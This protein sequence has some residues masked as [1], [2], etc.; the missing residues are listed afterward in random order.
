M[1]IQLYLYFLKFALCNNYSF[2]CYSS[3]LS[4]LSFTISIFLFFNPPTLIYVLQIYVLISQ[5]I[6]TDLL[7]LPD[8]IQITDCVKIWYSP[9][10]VSIVYLTVSAAIS[11]FLI[12]SSCRVLLFFFPLSLFTGDVFCVVKMDSEVIG[13]S[14]SS[15]PSLKLISSVVSALS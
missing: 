13:L 2:H 11:F 5:L 12:L 10:S 9:F 6:L 15:C 7:E 3:S 4:P 14:H 8:Q 1:L